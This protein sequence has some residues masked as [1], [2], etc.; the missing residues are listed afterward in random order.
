MKFLVKE[1]FAY[2]KLKRTLDKV[3]EENPLTILKCVEVN[4]SYNIWPKNTWNS[5]SNRE[6]CLTHVVHF[7][8]SLDISLYLWLKKKYWNRLVLTSCN[9]ALLFFWWCKQSFWDPWAVS[10]MYCMYISNLS[11]K[12][13]HDQRSH[14][15]SNSA[16]LLTNEI[17]SI[18]P[19]LSASI[20]KSIYQFHF[21]FLFQ[22]GTSRK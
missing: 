19:A 21:Q 20:V 22:I 11:N 10:S 14:R 2:K 8:S 9:M 1:S 13:G 12:S 16:L 15:K 17:S 5:K 3:L 6:K 7:Y 4:N 18:Q